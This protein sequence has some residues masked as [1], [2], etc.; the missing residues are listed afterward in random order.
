[1]FCIRCGKYIKGLTNKV[2]HS[3]AMEEHRYGHDCSKLH[4]VPLHDVPIQVA[5]NWL[6]RKT[7]IDGKEIT[8]R[9]LMMIDNKQFI[10]FNKRN[11]EEYANGSEER[12]R[13]LKEL[14]RKR[15]HNTNR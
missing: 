6:N 5:K 11:H 10:K 9:N 7:K 12:V 8:M 4:D 2:R 1:M 15:G 13:I 14:R 3:M